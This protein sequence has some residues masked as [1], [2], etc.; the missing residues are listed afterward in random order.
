M[1]KEHDFFEAYSQSKLAN[2][3]FSL[4]LARRY[5]PCGVTAVSLHPGGVKTNIFRHIRR[6]ISLFSIMFN[7]FTPFFLLFAK[8][9]KHGAQTIIYCALED[10]IERLN[11]KY[12]M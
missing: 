3:L 2:V 10:E 7:F 1:D 9:P 6:R 12:F 11:G 5:G 8:D 4:E